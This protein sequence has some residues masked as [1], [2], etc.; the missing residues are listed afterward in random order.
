MEIVDVSYL[1]TVPNYQDY[2]ANDLSLITATN[3]SPDFG[4]STDYV[5]YY[6]KDLNGFIVGQNYNARQ[7]IPTTNP[8]NALQNTT[9]TVTL[10]PENDAKSNGVNRGSF[11]VKYNFFRK[12]FNSDIG[13]YFWI[14]EISPSRSEIKVAR[15]DLSN[16]ELLNAF[17]AFNSAGISTSYYPDF[18]LNFGSD[19]QVIA[20]NVAYIEEDTDAYLVFK[21]YEPLPAD[22]DVL[23]QLWAVQRV[24]ESVEFQLN[25]DVE[26][27]VIVENNVLRGPNY[28]IALNQK[29]NQ[30]TPYYNYNSLFST[31]IT[32][33]Y[34]QLQSWLEDKSIS[35]NVDYSNFENFIHFSSATE[36]LLNFE[37]KLRLIE[38]YRADIAASN[39]INRAPATIIN[40]SKT[41]LQEKI[42]NIIT[43]FDGYEYYLYY[44]S[45]STAWPKENNIEPYR[46][47]SVTSSQAIDW[48]GDVNTVPTATAMSML[49][50]SSLYDNL[51]K[52]NLQYSMPAYIR[53]DDANQPY[54]T[55]LNMIGQHFDNIWIY[56]KDVSNRYSAE[57]NPQIGISMDLVADALRGFGVQLYTNS[58]IADNIYYS[59]LGINDTGSTLPL[60]SSQYAQLNLSSSS[61]T[62]LPGDEWLSS[63]VYLPPF[64]NENLNRYVTTFTTPST[65]VTASFA[66][67]PPMQLEKE[68]YKRIYHNLPYLLKTKG[69]QRGVKALIA[70]YGIP[71][72]I[73]TVN[74][75]GGNNIYAQPGIQQI[76][77]Q[78]VFTGSLLHLSSSLLSP[79]VTNQYYQNDTERGSPDVEIGFS[80]ADSI[81]AHITGTLGNLN[82]MQYMGAPSLQYSSSYEPLVALS[83]NYFATNYTTRYN[84]WDFIRIIKFYNNSLFKSIKDYVPARA[85]VS[86]AIIIKPHILERNKYA[87]H[88]PTYVT[89][90]FSQS[91]DTA[92]ISASDAP[93]LTYSTAYTQSV[94]G[95]LGPVEVNNSYGLEKY[96]GEFGGT[97]IQAAANDFPQI[98]NSNITAPWT[99]SILGGIETYTTYSIN[100]LLNNVSGSPLST[101]FFDLD[102]SANQIV[103]VNFDLITQ[104][105][106]AGQASLS[107]PYAPY[108]QIQDYNYYLQRST[109]PRYSGSRLSGRTYNTYTNGD[110]SYGSDPVIN[111]YTYQLGL[112]T[113]LSTSSYIPGKV[114][115]TLGYL[116]DVSGGLFELN[117][118]NKHWVDVQNI[119]KQSRYTTIKQWDNQKYSN[120]KSTDGSKPIWSSGYS[121][122]PMLYFASSSISPIGLLTYAVDATMSFTTT[123]VPLGLP[124]FRVVQGLGN[125]Q[126]FVTPGSVGT[127][128]YVPTSVGSLHSSVIIYDAFNDYTSPGGSTDGYYRQG[129]IDPLGVGKP[130][131]Y[132]TPPG[133]PTYGINAKTSVTWTYNQPGPVPT[134][135]VTIDLV[136]AISG[137]DPTN[138][139]YTYYTE[140][141]VTV[142]TNRVDTYTAYNGSLTYSIIGIPTNV[143]YSIT[144][145]RWRLI[146]QYT[147]P[148]LI[149]FTVNM[150]DG[151]WYLPNNQTITATATLVPTPS[152]PVQ[153]YV[154]YGRY[155]A[156][157]YVGGIYGWV[158]TTTFVDGYKFYTKNSSNQ[159]V[160]L[161]SVTD[162]IHTDLFGNYSTY[163]IG[164]NIFTRSSANTITGT[165]TL[166]ITTGVDYHPQGSSSSIYLKIENGDPTRFNYTINPGG[167]VESFSNSAVYVTS[168]AITNNFVTQI[169]GAV[170]QNYITLTDQLIPYHNNGYTYDPQGID[171]TGS[172]GQPAALSTLYNLYG[173]IVD[174]FKIESD[175]YLVIVDSSG[176][177]YQFEIDSVGI[178]QGQGIRLYLKQPIPATLQQGLTVP[179]SSGAISKF[180]LLKR[181][182]DEQN[183]ILNFPKKPGATS[184][185]FLLPDLTDPAV[186][187][188][189]NTLQATV[190]TQLLSTQAN[191]GQ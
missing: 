16:A 57:N 92:F 13:N 179:A 104:S 15:Q 144:T 84:V 37:Y 70:C 105:I 72:S 78:K 154:E 166:N 96:T 24:A 188:N 34:Q 36:R 185:G 68:Y 147:P 2:V 3:I 139:S 141:R 9:T 23:T 106:N 47:Y 79:Y 31:S 11:T 133:N 143:A 52:D 44:S 180:L 94:E 150:S 88:E 10:D 21:L 160:E 53:E 6:I 71:N 115:A 118:N 80:P 110:I 40:N 189:I 145:A 81:N 38:A 124:G 164:G 148:S 109:I 168:S 172:F 151:Q 64:G 184:Y 4:L 191:S 175:D 127:Y 101:R 18:L 108:A 1:G 74:E 136:L 190:Q 95:I 140:D 99:S 122:R 176:R 98:E 111:Y 138:P 61:L 134:T 187:D 167:F 97:I 19:V 114:N 59:M 58:N 121:Y 117:Q 157:Y 155:Q 158:A 153:L 33:S 120:Q 45:A 65:G 85:S 41:L 169:N 116:V 90:D 26:A 83:N 60:T 142:G 112:F 129:I 20:V 137:S 100:Y 17:T 12:L 182:K 50:S 173:D 123:A 135:P 39:S 149:P 93:A 73:L 82:M 146:T 32:S 170:N 126:Q 62:P 152:G 132:E 63:S 35:I 165:A 55:F 113:Q 161:I 91:I 77:N 25:I 76:Q 51:N 159:Y 181:Y 67:I 28:K 162:N 177:S 49:Y 86:S 130:A 125:A 103:P 14:K 107:N 174:P 46:L 119:F 183:V 75:F 102:Y 43:K 131:Y 66:T 171:V 163:A 54:M 42:D 56:Y 87:R 8:A 128:Q 89:L 29:Q 69:T 27:D 22:Y 7:Y 178:V 186:V 48:L 30:T 156:D 5:E